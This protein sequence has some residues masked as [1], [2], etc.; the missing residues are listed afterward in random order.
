MSDP[1]G[2][3][4]GREMDR[5]AERTFQIMLHFELVAVITLAIVSLILVG[6]C[7]RDLARQERKKES[8]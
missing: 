1:I 6:L 3:L 2:E 4:L 8:G 7:C 5:I